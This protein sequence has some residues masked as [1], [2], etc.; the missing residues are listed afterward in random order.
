MT[1]VLYIIGKDFNGGPEPTFD[2]LDAALAAARVEAD[3]TGVPV[4]VYEA[5][6]FKGATEKVV[7]FPYVEE[8]VQA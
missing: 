3:R 1:E 6:Q 4:P 8:G 7:V 5:D 2:T